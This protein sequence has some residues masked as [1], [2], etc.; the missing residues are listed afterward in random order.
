[1]KRKKNGSNGVK[2]GK[3]VR[4]GDTGEDSDNYPEEGVHLLIE[5][6]YAVRGNEE[7]K[8]IP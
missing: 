5:Q 8:G 7:I 3:A 1:L 4:K 2:S 6:E